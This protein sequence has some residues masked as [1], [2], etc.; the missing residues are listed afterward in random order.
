MLDKIGNTNEA[1]ID[2]ASHNGNNAGLKLGGDIVTVDA[3][4]LNQLKGMN[5]T[6]LSELS[7]RYTKGEADDEF[8]PAIGSTLITTAGTLTTGTLSTNG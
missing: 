3:S 8:S 7:N 4:E 2:I 5:N 1:Q 6:V